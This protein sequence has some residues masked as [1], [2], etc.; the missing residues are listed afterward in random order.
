MCLLH[1]ID[2]KMMIMVMVMVHHCTAPIILATRERFMCEIVVADLPEAM[3]YWMGFTIIIMIFESSHNLYAPDGG[4][5]AKMC[6]LHQIDQ[7][8]GKTL[9]NVEDD[10]DDD[11]STNY[12]ILATREC[13]VFEIV[14]A[15]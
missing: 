10:D 3:E 4:R 5:H 12:H 6:L 11:A 2:Q 14:V 9:D 8:I 15:I 13:F 7:K 1:Q